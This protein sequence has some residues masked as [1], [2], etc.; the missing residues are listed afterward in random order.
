MKRY[1][2][3]L[4]VIILATTTTG[5]LGAAKG[6]GLTIGNG[7]LTIGPSQEARDDIAQGKAALENTIEKN[8]SAA[9]IEQGELDG[10]A[11]REA[12]DQIAL[13][14]AVAAVVVGVGF[15][16]KQAAPLAREA[17]GALDAALEL[18]RSKR[19][20][21][22]LEVG[23][24]GY[25]GHLLA[26]GY[27]QAEITD[28]VHQTP[29]LDAPRVQQLQIQAGPRGMRILAERGEVE[30]TLALMPSTVEAEEVIIGD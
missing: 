12:L 17:V 23:P 9:K 28:L 15:G 25:A 10:E 20:E 3:I 4:A 5:C 2:F 22:T 19:L 6:E 27:T 13:A 21:I 11:R 1:V 16:G 18:R 14:A 30:E 29:V 24:N 26:E 8:E 7:L